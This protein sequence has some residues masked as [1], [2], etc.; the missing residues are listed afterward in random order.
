MRYF[1]KLKDKSEELSGMR[2]RKLETG[3][4]EK[5]EKRGRAVEEEKKGKETGRKERRKKVN[6]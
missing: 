1:I 5:G 2:R 6:C 4:Y 3:K